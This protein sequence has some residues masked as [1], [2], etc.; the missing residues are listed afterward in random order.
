MKKTNLYIEK[1]PTTIWGA[2]SEKVYLYVHGQGG[3]KE[4]S[5]LF[6]NIATNHGYQVISIDLPEHGERKTEKTT[7]EP[8]NIV[9]ELSAVM[10]YCKQRWR[11]VSLFANSIGAW[12]SML[13]FSDEQ[14]NRGLFVSPVVDMADLISDMMTWADVSESQLEHD[15]IVPTTFGQT[16]SWE[17]LLYAKDHPIDKWT[18]PTQILYGEKDTLIKCATVEAFCKKHNCELTV[19]KNG[20][21][22]FHTKQQLDILTGWADKSFQTTALHH[23]ISH[24]H[25]R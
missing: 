5:Q 17:Y 9:P 13:A 16:L 19:M 22:W 20:E 1:I 24:S 10:T 18:T 4:E 25:I 23:G 21:H 15:K 8:W 12:F 2:H 11:E 3:Q 6:A 14:L 7:F